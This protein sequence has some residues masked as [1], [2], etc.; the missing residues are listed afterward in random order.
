MVYTKMVY[1]HVL[2]VNYIDCHLPQLI[3]LPDVIIDER[4]I[5]EPCYNS[6]LLIFYRNSKIVDYSKCIFTKGF[7]CSLMPCRSANFN[8]FSSFLITFVTTSGSYFMFNF[9][10]F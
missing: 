7:S 9:I 1:I 5:I 3:E 6:V 2:F 8:F 10:L 4:K